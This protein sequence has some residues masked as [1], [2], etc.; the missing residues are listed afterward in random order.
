MNT[1]DVIRL[2][3]RQNGISVTDLE[4]DL[5]F[6]N[7][8]LLKNNS[9]RSDRLYKVAQRFNVSMEYLT[10]GQDSEK[11]SAEG[12]K[13]YFDDDTAQKA[14]ELFDNPDLRMLFDAARDSKPEDLQMAAD[15]LKR[16]KETNPDG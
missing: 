16:F 6:S 7:G 12:N 1:T 9:I 11:V 14:Q 4:K 10:T 15:M 8:S 5:G 2:L 13:Y 3:C